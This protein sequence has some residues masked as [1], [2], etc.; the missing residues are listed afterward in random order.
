[1]ARGVT[2]VLLGT[3][4]EAEALA[5]IAAACPQAR[6]LC[7]QTDLADIAVLARSALVAVGNDTGPMHLIAAAGCPVV[8]L[9]SAGTDPAKV[10]PRGRLVA[11]RQRA[12][13][14][15]LPLEDVLAALPPAL[16]NAKPEANF[17][18]RGP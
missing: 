1:M 11:V 5:E 12:E 4:L 13:L 3:D 16:P 10:A 9:F 2:P 18:T 7:G 14:A 8:A 17:D 6:N 15:D